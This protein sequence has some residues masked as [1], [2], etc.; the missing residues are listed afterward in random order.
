MRLQTAIIL[1]LTLAGFALR[2]HFLITT[3][4]FFDEY[5]TVLAARQVLQRGWPILPSGLFY[6]H[7][8]LATYM[9]TPFTA[10]FINM[11]LSQWQTAHWAK[12]KGLFTE[13]FDS[14]AQLDEYLVRFTH[15]LAA[16]SPEAMREL[17]TVLWRGTEDWPILLEQRAE[18]SGRL[19][20]SDF[21]KKAIA[22]FKTKP[23]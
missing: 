19:V 3:H 8:L 12:D 16:F 18:R 2:L 23:S 20:L 5:T 1:I 15:R 10:L 7:G 9:I 14:V 11:P 6:E 13:V 21:T 22:A 4:P 17:K